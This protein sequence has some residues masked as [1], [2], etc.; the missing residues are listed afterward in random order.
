MRLSINF[1]LIKSLDHNKRKKYF[2][3]QKKTEEKL[4][5]KTI[6]KEITKSR[7]VFI[8]L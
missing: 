1:C 5:N 3:L 8:I 7:T 6:F 2:R 4:K